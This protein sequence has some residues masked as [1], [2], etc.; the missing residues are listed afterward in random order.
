M[1]PTLPQSV[2]ASALAI[3]ALGV[4][5]AQVKPNAASPVFVQTTS[6]SGGQTSALLAN[7]P[8]PNSATRKLFSSTRQTSVWQERAYYSVVGIPESMSNAYAQQIVAAGWTAATRVTSGNTTTQFTLDFTKGE[9]KAHLVV[10][11]N[12]TEGTT[13]SVTLT[14]LFSQSTPALSAGLMVEA[15]SGGTASA[16]DRGARDPSDFPR[17]PGTIRSSFD[18]LVDP[19]GTREEAAYTAIS[20]PANADAFYAQ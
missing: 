1:R 10:A 4:M 2:L 17:L 3:L 16:S 7:F 11:Q 8:V 6:P 13:L 9:T 15:A 19:S 14:T 18:S 5:H 12:P 20:A